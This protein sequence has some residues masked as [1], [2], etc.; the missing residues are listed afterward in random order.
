MPLF[1]EDVII[2]ILADSTSGVREM[3]KTNAELKAMGSQ[4]KMSA[5]NLMAIGASFGGITAAIDLGVKAIT[6]YVEKVKAAE[7]A[8]IKWAQEQSNYTTEGLEAIEALNAAKEEQA[9]VDGKLHNDYM[10]N[11]R[12]RRAARLEES[13][14]VKQMTTEQLAR[15]RE[16]NAGLTKFNENFQSR[17]DFMLEEEE[18]LRRVT[19]LERER[20][21]AYAQLGRAL[22]GI[23]EFAT[24]E[25]TRLA[26]MQAIIATE[27]RHIETLAM[28]GVI[29]DEAA[30]KTAF[31]NKVVND[32]VRGEGGYAEW[33]EFISGSGGLIEQIAALNAGLDK[34]AAKTTAVKDAIPAM[35]D[36]I[37]AGMVSA[38]DA[39]NS[40]G[41]AF[42]TFIGQAFGETKGAAIAQALINQALAITNIWSQFGAFPPLAATLS[43]L[44]LATTGLQISK[45]QSQSYANG[46]PP[47]G[48]TGT[49]DDSI[50]RVS[51]RERL[52]V[53]RDNG[54]PSGGGMMGDVYLDGQK[55]GR[56]FN[57]ASDRNLIRPNSRSVVTR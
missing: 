22:A 10:A 38:L 5:K 6:A 11:W 46:T 43:T 50:V 39:V 4:A 44:A 21:D 54:E 25:D 20:I 9:R 1:T 31:L 41:G 23:G 12:T 28:L 34:T 56:W 17:L 27:M 33:T 19:A 42:N 40:L 36:T 24:E 3:K 32:L 13:T 15:W 45:I 8:Y 14:V 48:Y 37:E 49:S 53:Q 35:T 16:A 51:S 26:D 2:R 52:H 18:N 29:T 47:G 30:V 7:D 57:S 55:V